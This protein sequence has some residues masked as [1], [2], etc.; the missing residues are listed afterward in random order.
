MF[1]YENGIFREPTLKT[2]EMVSVEGIE[3][4]TKRSFNNMPGHG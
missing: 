2:K 4:A 1:D 3:S